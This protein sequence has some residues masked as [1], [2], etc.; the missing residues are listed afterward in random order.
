MRFITALFLIIAGSFDSRDS[1]I[2]AEPVDASVVFI[3]AGYME[4]GVFIR[5]E[6]GTGFIVHPD[7]WVVTA[8]HVT[9]VAVPEGKIRQFRGAVASFTAPPSQLFE[10][11]APVVSS[12][13][14]L[15]RFSPHLRPASNPW[16]CLKVKASHSFRNG[17][18][19]TAYGF[20][21]GK[22]LAVR[23]GVVSELLGPKGSI[24]VNAGLAPG[25]SGGP[26]VL[27]E[28]RC[29]IGIVAGGSGYP[30]F[31]YFTPAQYAKPLL[32]VPPAEFVT[33]VTPSGG[34]ANASKAPLFDRSYQVDQTRDEHSDANRTSKDYAFDFQADSDAKIISARYIETSANAASDKVINISADRTKA[35]FKVRLESGPFYDRWRGWWHGQIILTQQR[36]SGPNPSKAG[37]S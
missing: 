29:V 8:K 10:A 7:G 36:E 2:A 3:E 12:D 17:D 31:D 27:S 24:G 21:V 25:M 30:T 14:A 4:G 28:T 26:V 37:C 13:V 5:V 22:E 33:E 1:A 11:P 35:T 16:N 34:D 32:E 18:K 15:L 20:P 6:L 9:E 23:P 19:I